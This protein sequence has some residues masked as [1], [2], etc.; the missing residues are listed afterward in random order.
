MAINWRIY[1]PVKD[2]NMLGMGNPPLFPPLFPPLPPSPPEPPDPPEPPEPL[3]HG[4]MFP[5][6]KDEGSVG[7]PPGSPN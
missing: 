5:P 4:I 7:I 6:G 1:R 2:G 3:P